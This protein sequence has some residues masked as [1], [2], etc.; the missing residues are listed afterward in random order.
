MSRIVCR[1]TFRGVG[2]VKRIGIYNR[3]YAR[4]HFSASHVAETIER[5]CNEVLKTPLRLNLVS[6]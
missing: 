4:T 5:I 2:L 3:N 6:S 1:R